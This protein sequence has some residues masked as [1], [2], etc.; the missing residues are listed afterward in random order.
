MQGVKIS[1]VSLRLR[2]RRSRKIW[3]GKISRIRLKGQ[4]NKLLLLRL[5][6]ILKKENK[7]SKIK[8]PTRENKKKKQSRCLKRSKQ[9]PGANLF[10]SIDFTAVN[11][12][13]I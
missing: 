1:W 2:I 9:K 12:P 8:R 10:S 11:Q 5:R 3:I 6:M 4:F 7:N 13:T